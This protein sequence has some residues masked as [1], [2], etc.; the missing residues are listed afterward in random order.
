MKKTAREGGL[1]TSIFTL[2]ELLFRGQPYRKKVPGTVKCLK[3][4][5]GMTDKK[6]GEA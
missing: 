6:K 3:T 5:P 2:L 1:I 4:E